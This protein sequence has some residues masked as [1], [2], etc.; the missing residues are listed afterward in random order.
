VRTRNRPSVVIRR[1]DENLADAF[2]L[3]HGPLGAPP[4]GR[5][6]TGLKPS[7]CDRPVEFVVAGASPGVEE[8]TQHR[9]EF[10]QVHGLYRRSRVPWRRAGRRLSSEHRASSG[11]NVGMRWTSAA[12]R[13]HTSGRSLG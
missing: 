3:A 9:P 12:S 4:A 7:S 5:R 10:D 6:V 8:V 11:Q 2:R 1:V 13:A